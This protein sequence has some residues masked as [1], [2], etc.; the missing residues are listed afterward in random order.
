MG[1]YDEAYAYDREL[2]RQSKT[3]KIMGNFLQE[4]QTLTKNYNSPKIQEIKKRIKVAAATGKTRATFMYTFYD[5]DTINWLESEGFIVTE[6]NDFRD[7][8]F[9][10]VTW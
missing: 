6:T 7:G 4:V 9:I 1:H 2:D 5:K 8:D 3:I 10:T